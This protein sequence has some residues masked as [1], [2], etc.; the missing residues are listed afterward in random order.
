MNNHAQ[1]S[2]SQSSELLDS[3]SAQRSGL[4]AQDLDRYLPAILDS[5]AGELA[6]VQGILNKLARTINEQSQQIA[7]VAASLATRKPD[8]ELRRLLAELIARVKRLADRE[9]VQHSS[10]ST[11]FDN[12]PFLSEEPN[13]SPFAGPL[14][15]MS[16]AAGAQTDDS[17][18]TELELPGLE[19]L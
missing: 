17:A 6:D 1:R 14:E 7:D 3:G 19:L 9:S 4:S 13:A 5:F 2:D 15:T 11:T 8:S 12:V 16:S 18:T 10:E